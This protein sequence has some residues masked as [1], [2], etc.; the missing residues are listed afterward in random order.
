M[1]RQ[2]GSSSSVT[3]SQCWKRRL[4]SQKKT[5]D[6]E[7]DPEKKKGLEAALKQATA[8]RDGVKK[9]REGLEREI[10]RAMVMKER[11]EV[12]PTH[13][14]VRGQ[15][16]VPGELVERNTPAFL[17]PLEKAG[18]VAT[19]MDLANWF[20]DPQNPLTARVAVNRFWQQLFGVGLVKT[21]EDLGAQ[22]E[23]PSHPE[24]LDYLALSLVDSGWD[25][26]SLMKQIVMSQTY[27]QASEASPDQF[28]ADPE[29]RFLARGSRFRMDAEMIRDQILASS[30]LLVTKVGGKSVKPP[31]PDGLWKA[32]TMI[33]ERF[34]PD[35][36]DAIYRRSLYTYWKRG[37]P[38]PQ[39]TILNAPV[40]DACTARRERTNTPS[41]ALLLLNEGEYLNAARNLAAQI[42]KSYKERGGGD[43]SHGISPRLR[44]RHEPRAG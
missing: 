44:D 14:R 37:M 28:E 29:N 8:K 7:T 26:K 32:V 15:Y 35:S 27:Q 16:D 40:R 10:P 42:Q 11:A 5:V 18:D 3:R 13:L 39:M 41:Q 21:S 34:K 22:G 43:P 36:G 25:I 30:G 23:V 38:P 17:P 20:V 2:S 33:G 1:S 19:R 31:Q 4:T 12:R 9:Q 6:G 24:L